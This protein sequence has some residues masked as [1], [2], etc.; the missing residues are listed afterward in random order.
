MQSNYLILC[1]NL[2]L[3]KTCKIANSAGKTQILLFKEIISKDLIQL[4]E[5]SAETLQL[6]AKKQKHSRGC[7]ITVMRLF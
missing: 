3:N 2:N 1:C 5:D 4:L 6:F 7:H